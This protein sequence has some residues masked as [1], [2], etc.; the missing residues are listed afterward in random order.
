MGAPPRAPYELK[1]KKE[2]S[3]QLCGVARGAGKLVFSSFN[4]R[5]R[6]GCFMSFDAI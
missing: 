4:Q 6:P 1:R 3:V 2:E 5:Q